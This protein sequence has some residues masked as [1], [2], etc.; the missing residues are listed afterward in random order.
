MAMGL[1]NTKR[2]PSSIW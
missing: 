2:S 1:F